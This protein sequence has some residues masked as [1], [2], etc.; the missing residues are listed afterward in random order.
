[1]KVI[2]YATASKH[3]FE[4]FEKEIEQRK[5]MKELHK[6]GVQPVPCVLVEGIPGEAAAKWLELNK[7]KKL[8]KEDI[9]NGNNKN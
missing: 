7:Y 2:K 3:G 4:Q 5:H 8:I 6:R 1:M 9:A